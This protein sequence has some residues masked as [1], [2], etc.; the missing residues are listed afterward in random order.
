MDWIG[1]D[2]IDDELRL[3]W[4]VRY[5]DEIQCDRLVELRKALKPALEKQGVKLSYL[6]IMIKVVQFQ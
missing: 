5:G 4:C 1:L 3:V 2:W 6:P